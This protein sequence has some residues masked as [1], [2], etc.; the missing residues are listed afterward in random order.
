MHPLFFSIFTDI[1]Q[2]PDLSVFEQLDEVPNDMPK[3]PCPPPTIAPAY[4]KM[5]ARSP[6]SCDSEYSY[7]SPSP[8]HSPSV[9]EAGSS[10]YSTD[11]GIVEDISDLEGEKMILTKYFLLTNNDVRRNL[12]LITELANFLSLFHAF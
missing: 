10:A 3:E 5:E 11:E 2:P 12:L 1:D 6:S 4:M 9:S 8:P 7:S